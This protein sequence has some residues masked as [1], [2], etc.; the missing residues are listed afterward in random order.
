MCYLHA[1]CLLAEVDESTGLYSSTPISGLVLSSR[2]GHLGSALLGVTRSKGTRPRRQIHLAGCQ[3]RYPPGQLVV[4]NVRHYCRFLVKAGHYNC[5]QDAVLLGKMVCLSGAYRDI[6]ARCLKSA[7]REIEESSVHALPKYSHSLYPLEIIISGNLCV[8][9]CVRLRVCVC[10]RV[11]VCWGGRQFALFDLCQKNFLAA[12]SIP[13]PFGLDQ[14][15]D[16]VSRAAGLASW[17][18]VCLC[19]CASVRVGRR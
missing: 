9:V 16:V 1:H 3:L 18:T 7:C 5:K 12:L 15:R 17:H 10:A 8:R 2:L 19:S 13:F 4:Y 14:D 11:W 6:S